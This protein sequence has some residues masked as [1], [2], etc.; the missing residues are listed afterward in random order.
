M[1]SS[2]MAT[3]PRSWWKRSAALRSDGESLA[4]DAGGGVGG[5]RLSPWAP[6]R[7]PPSGGLGSSLSARCTH[8]PALSWRNHFIAEALYPAAPG[9]VQ[10]AQMR[11]VGVWK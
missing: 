3:S 5:S 11:P 7:G 8:L 9:R 2:S 1:R 6:M 4:N 10:Q